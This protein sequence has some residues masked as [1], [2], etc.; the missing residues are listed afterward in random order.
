LKSLIFSGANIFF[1]GHAATLEVCTRQLCSLPPRSYS[2]FNGVIRKVSYL[3]LQLCERN[4]SDG[5]WT[6]KTPPIPPLQHA[7][8]VSF[9]WQTMK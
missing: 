1:I 5:Q 8:N 7:N 3:G 6:L 2:D 4:P 9:D